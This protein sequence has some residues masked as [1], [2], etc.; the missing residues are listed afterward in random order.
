VGATQR[1]ATLIRLNA[2]PHLATFSHKGRRKTD[3]HLLLVTLTKVRVQLKR[4]QAG[5]Q[6]CRNDE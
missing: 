5:I 2:E 1:E 6:L 4:L 3:A